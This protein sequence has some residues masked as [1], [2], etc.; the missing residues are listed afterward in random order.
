MS[1]NFSLD[2]QKQEAKNKA[3]QVFTWSNAQRSEFRRK[4]REREFPEEIWQAFARN[5]FLGCLIPE[6][7]AGNAAGLLTLS[8]IFEEMGASGFI[9]ALPMLTNMSTVSI[10]RHGSE[11]LQNR[12]LPPLARGEHK[13]CVAATEE[14]SGNNMFRIQTFAENKSD[15]YLVNGRKVYISGADIADYMLVLARTQTPEQCQQQGLPKTFGLSIFFV[16]TDSPGIRKEIMPTHGESSLRQHVVQFDNLKIPVENRI[17]E[18]HQGAFI[19]FDAINVER[20]LGASIALGISQ[21]CLNRAVEYAKERTIFGKSP[22]GQYQAIQHPLAD[23]TIRQK[24]VRLLAY[25]AASLF[26][27]GADPFTVGSRANSAKYLASELSLK[28]V[29]AAIETLGGKGFH[30]DYDLIHLWED[31]RLFKTAPTSNSM[32]LNF[33]AEHELGLPRSY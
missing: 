13:C 5:G 4:I 23:I 10:A 2:T 30:E 24:A 17:G 8:L 33:V 11:H 1:F 32:L 15:Y 20:I 6:E 7:F 31:V 12:L 19:M 3:R 28:A 9:N 27:E 16:A 21:H 26:D 14:V 29:D 18:E 22:I 25:E